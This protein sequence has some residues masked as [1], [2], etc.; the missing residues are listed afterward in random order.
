[1][2]R[3]SFQNASWIVLSSATPLLLHLGRTSKCTHKHSGRKLASKNLGR[4]GRN[5]C[6]PMLHRFS[7]EISQGKQPMAM[8][9]G[10]RLNIHG[11]TVSR[12][13]LEINSNGWYFEQSVFQKLQENICSD[14]SIVCFSVPGKRHPDSP[15]QMLLSTT[16]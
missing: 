12:D 13:H 7:P 15:R 16:S 10:S 4:R 1:M 11:G 3:S 2:V 9:P 14:I 5:I 8:P 6:L